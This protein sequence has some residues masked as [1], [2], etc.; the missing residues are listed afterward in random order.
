MWGGLIFVC[1]K[2][3]FSNTDSQFVSV[4]IK[5]VVF[6]TYGMGDDSLSFLGFPDVEVVFKRRL[7]LSHSNKKKND[8]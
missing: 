1:K 4:F 6:G 8:M 5:I 7:A 3:I 2:L